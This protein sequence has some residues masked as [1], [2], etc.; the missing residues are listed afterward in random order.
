[1]KIC[2]IYKIQS[3]R[4]PNRIY[5]GS[6]VNIIDRWK[7]HIYK[8]RNKK[9]EN[10]LLQ[11]HFNKYGLNDLQFIILI[12][13]ERNDLKDTEEFFINSFNPYFNLDKFSSNCSG[14]RLPHKIRIN[15]I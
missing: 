1:M 13:C 5:I 2:G 10:H 6:S 12:G 14:L 9:H 7:N 3:K 15:I 8:L 11:N 4:K